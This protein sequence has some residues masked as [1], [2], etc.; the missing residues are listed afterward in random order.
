M[1]ASSLATVTDC[2]GPA[3]ARAVG[4][5]RATRTAPTS[6]G[7]PTSPCPAPVSWG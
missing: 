4:G 3:A 2:V 5:G 6:A 7:S 1:G